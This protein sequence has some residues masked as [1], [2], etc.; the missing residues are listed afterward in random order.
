MANTIEEAAKIHAEKCWGIYIYDIDEDCNETRGN[1]TIDAFKEGAKSEEAKEYWQSK[2][3]PALD[4]YDAISQDLNRQIVELREAMNTF[5]KTEDISSI[6]DYARLQTR[7]NCCI[8]LSREM[9]KAKK[10]IIK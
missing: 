10:L 3:Q 7:I 5:K 9:D 6:T 1:L 4:S 2:L 8:H